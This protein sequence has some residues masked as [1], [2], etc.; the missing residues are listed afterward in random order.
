MALSLGIIAF[1]SVLRLPVWRPRQMLHSRSANCSR[2]TGLS[3]NSPTKGIAMSPV[4][5]NWL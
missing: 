5:L 4:P 2:S 3:Q 1:T